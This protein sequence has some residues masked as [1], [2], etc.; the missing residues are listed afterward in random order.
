MTSN[1]IRLIRTS[2]VAL[3]VT[4]GILGCS[5]GKRNKTTR[6]QE[7]RELRPFITFAQPEVP[8]VDFSRMAV[9]PAL[10]PRPPW[11]NTPRD[12]PLRLATNLNH[13]R[14][15][16]V[17]EHKTNLSPQWGFFCYY[18][19]D[20]MHIKVNTNLVYEFFRLKGV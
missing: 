2:L 7:L 1:Q 19:N 18:T 16:W 14:Y 10:P 3:V 12:L 9:I 20:L 5:V 6:L 15:S 8:R 13:L 11:I 4:G 17:V